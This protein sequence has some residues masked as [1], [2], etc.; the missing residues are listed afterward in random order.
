MVAESTVVRAARR[1]ALLVASI[2]SLATAQGGFTSRSAGFGITVALPS[3]WELMSKAEV[4]ATRE[5]TI[6]GMRASGVAALR[7]FAASN[8][9]APLFHARDTQRR[10][11]FSNMNV[12]VRPGVTRD[13]FA[14]LGPKDT[15]ALV[16]EL[17][18]AFVAQTASMGGTGR[19]RRHETVTLEDRKVLVIYQEASVLRAGLENTRTVVML[20]ADGL[21]FTLSV[22]VHRADYD[23]AVVR[24]ILGSVRFPA[25]L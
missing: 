10:A 18:Q 21:L 16:G 24:A 5:R 25:T 1:F 15:D 9:N 2:P 3:S 20:P 6:D 4:A 17:C 13:L 23:P 22:S 14:K 7:A 8:E 19:C 12:T 11:N